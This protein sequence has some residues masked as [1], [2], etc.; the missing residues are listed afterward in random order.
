MAAEIKKE[1]QLEIAHVLFIDIVGYSKLSI[2]EQHA[3]VEEL[4][5][6]VRAS[7]QFQRAEAA[8]R[9]IRIPTG[10]GMVLV[11][12]TN[13]EAPV[14]CAVEIN[15]ALKEQPRLQVRMGI[16]SGPVSGV[17]DVNER[18]NLTGAGINLARRVMDCG[19]AGHILLSKHVA[20]DLEEYEKW[21]PFLHDLGT[22]EVKHGVRVSVV[23][24]YDDQ[25][26]NAKLPRNFETV[27]KRRMRL[28][29][30][31]VA[32]ALLVLAAIIAAFVL[33]LRRSTHSAV[34]IGE[35]SI[36][37][38]PF[39]NLSR[40]PDNA[41]F[42]DGVQ[43]EIL[44]DL[45]RIADLKVIS[46]TS[47]IQYKSG[48]PRNLREIGQQLGV[49]HVLEGS[50]QRAANKIRV[51]A[52]LVDTRS[53]AHLWAQTYDR[54]LADVFAIQSEISK[55]I[56]DQLQA[57]LSPREA[58]AVQEK[59]TN[60]IVAYDLYLKAMEIDRNRASSVGSGGI[61]GARREVELLDQATNHDPAF[62]AALCSLASVHLY[63]YWLNADHTPARLAM[64]TKA[65]DAAARLHPDSGEVHVTRA[66][67]YYWGARD[68]EAALAE[69]SLAKR[70]LPNNSQ[71]FGLSGFIERRKGNWDDATRHIEQAL[72]LDPRNIINVSELAATY[73][74]L[75]R[76]EDATKTL[77]NALAWKPD[78]FSLALQRAS[79]DMEWK[80]DLRR[81]KQVV[82]GEAAKNAYANDLIT[83]R[84]NLALKER[85]YH[86]AEQT[87]AR[88]GG[89]E[90]DDNGFFTPREWNQG[91][92]AS[93]L[94]DK[95][96]AQAAFL[97][98]RERV[99][100][101][102][103]DQPDDGK[104]L[105]VLAQID[106]VLGRKED[107][108]RE[109]QRAIELIPITKDALIGNLLLNQLAG[110]Y[111]QA[112]EADHAFNLLEKMAKIPFGV[113][114][115]WLKLES[116]WDPLRRDPRFDKIVASLAPKKP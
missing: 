6:I 12:Y 61:E 108:L 2:N 66:L 78:D 17:L 82:S 96:R 41:F 58:A 44:T 47:V 62:V 36:A 110:V 100:S 5:R 68:Y 97:T 91:L 1:I 94:G 15:R 46:R 34:A 67:Y 83:A 80:A 16:H 57:K 23:N 30:A 8:N 79:V 112:G 103:R 43:D 102:V 53:D 13:P 54:D 86:Q 24:L 40:D 29:W 49:A 111:A 35:K 14:Q 33:L 45:A 20:E 89:A 42:T 81:W 3:A 32:V 93:G 64:A 65:L 28:R 92:V 59:P 71:I 55:A 116:V 73:I 7:E 84:L 70:S 21:R 107:A 105:M 74:A 72:L 37:V 113:S 95:P 98:A 50:V 88:G 18:A 38:L 101:A 69:L 31:E 51:N 11:F 109:G 106:A 10:D 104:P 48:A 26:G 99:A 22:C 60:N 90:F 85:D 76:Y 56:A 4:N 63:L 114:Y 27:Q 87:L 9:L 115:G 75:R 77:D 25:F 39:E 52:Q 19:D